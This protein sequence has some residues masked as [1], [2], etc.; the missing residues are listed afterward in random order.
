M[1]KVMRKLKKSKKPFR[2]L[3][4]G[5][6]IV[7]LITF[8][9]FTGSLISLKGIETLLRVILIIFFMLYI[10]I[11]AFWNLLNLLRKKYKGLFITSIISVVFILIFS[12][13][14]YYI[15]F[16]YN[17]LLNMATYIL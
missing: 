14:S 11:Y 3:Y 9:M 7:Y 12:V 17:N 6:I 4:Y 8:I 13:C 5:V 15:N 10:L 16:V 2:I 1:N